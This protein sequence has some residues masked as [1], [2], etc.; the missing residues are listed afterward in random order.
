MPHNGI[1]VM[2]LTRGR[3]G[4]QPTLEALLGKEVR[5]VAQ[6]AILVCPKDE[7]KAH[8]EWLKK[9]DQGFRVTV[10]P[11]PPSVTALGLSGKREWCLKWCLENEYKVCAQFDDDLQFF[12]RK[13]AEDWHLQKNEPEDNWGMIQLLDHWVRKDGFSLAGVSARQG[14]NRHEDLASIATRQCTVHFY[15][16]DTAQYELK[17]KHRDNMGVEWPVIQDHY[18]TLN[19]LCRGHLNIVT[20]YFAADQ[21][22]GSPGGCS[23]YRTPELH[24]EIVTKLAERFPEFVKLRKVKY[25]SFNGLE[26]TEPTIYWKKA[27]AAAWDVRVKDL[28]LHLPERIM[29]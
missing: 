9:M 18:Y 25:G 29:P 5:D 13:S 12:H 7:A 17:T 15:N 8:T 1:A 14:N 6:H 20:N 28:V 26:R 3:V 21:V 4:N 11:V 22:F 23:I 19:N 2:V 27:L 10:M 16:V 24:T